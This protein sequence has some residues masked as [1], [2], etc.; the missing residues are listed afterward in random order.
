[1][2]GTPIKLTLYDENNEI[3]GEFSRSFVPW[4]LLKSAIRMQKTVSETGLENLSTEEVD[5]LAGLVVEVFGNK[6]S[7]QDCD[8]GADISDMYAVIT[9][10]VSKASGLTPGNPTSPGK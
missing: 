7:V 1:M 6:F 4:K 2:P 3:I 8:N 10:I 5:A 9:A